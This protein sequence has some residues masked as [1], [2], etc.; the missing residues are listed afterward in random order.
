[1]TA[2]RAT[3]IVTTTTTQT[4]AAKL[5]ETSASSQG[6]N[7]TT[8]QSQAKPSRAHTSSQQA[9]PQSPKHPHHHHHHQSNSLAPTSRCSTAGIPSLID[10][11]PITKP[12]LTD[13]TANNNN[14]SQ[15]GSCVTSNSNAPN[16]NSNVNNNNNPQQA[17][18]GRNTPQ[19][20]QVNIAPVQP[21]P[22]SSAQT[23]TPLQQYSLFNDSKVIFVFIYYSYLKIHTPFTGPAVILL[24][25]YEK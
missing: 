10:S 21:T 2:G 13:V 15:N 18:Q 22:R 16:T 6:A 20:E 7:T 17:S 24:S 14:Q 1:M 25:F 5:T 4:F 11:A 9:I 12:F 23:I 3:K 8:T 19:Q